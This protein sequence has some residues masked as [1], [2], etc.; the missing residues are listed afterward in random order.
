[1]MSELK[2]K[3]VLETLDVVKNVKLGI[4]PNH[5]AWRNLLNEIY[6]EVHKDE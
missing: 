2:F 5:Q 4:I 1:M 3:E 6:N